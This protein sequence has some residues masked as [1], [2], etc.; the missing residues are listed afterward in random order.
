MTELVNLGMEDLSL[1][2]LDIAENS[3]AAGARNIRITIAEDVSSDLLRIDV[4]DDGKG[5]QPEELNRAGDPFYTTKPGHNAGLGL[6]LLKQAAKESDGG[7]EITSSPGHG[8]TVTATFQ[9]SH[10][11]CKPLG[12]MTDTIITLV[13]ACEDVDIV[14]VH[15][16]GGRKVVFDTKDIR[17]ELAGDPLQSAKGR[18]VIRG[19]LS[20]E[21]DSLTH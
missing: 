4:A 3:V 10:P 14:Y 19:Y 13:T 5:M 2:I 11:N 21:E 20:Q 17:E 8:T 18:A 6:S 16:W 9:A 12:N 1:H 7:M 15:A